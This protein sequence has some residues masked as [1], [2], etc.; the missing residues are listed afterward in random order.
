MVAFAVIGALCGG[1]GIGDG[2]GDDDT[3]KAPS[4]IGSASAGDGRAA[5]E[6]WGGR[7]LMPGKSPDLPAVVT[8]GPLLAKPA[9]SRTVLAADSGA[10]W[11]LDLEA[12]STFLWPLRYTTL[13][14]TTNMDVGPA[15]NQIC[16]WDGKTGVALQSCTT[17]TTCSVAVTRG[18]ADYTSFTAVVTPAPPSTV[19]PTVNCGVGPAVASSFVDVLWHSTGLWLTETAPTVP[20][21][22]TTTLT[23][24]TDYDVGPSPFFVE[25]YDVT[26]AT[27]IRSCGGTPP[28]HQGEPTRC[29]VDVSYAVATTHQYRAC[30]MGASPSFPPPNALEC[31]RDQSVSWANANGT[32]R[33]LLTVTPPPNPGGNYTATAYST[34]NVGPTPY[35]IQIYNLETGSRIAVCGSGTA[36]SAPITLGVNAQNLVGFVGTYSAT[37][38]V[39]LQPGTV[40]SNSLTVPAPPQDGQGTPV[41][42][43]PVIGPNGIPQ[44]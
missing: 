27:M 20:L 3:G 28:P 18:N 7:K 36:C 41:T 29:S 9:A 42:Q 1:C 38:P 5:F 16:I 2:V 4:A 12:S 23:A 19:P 40:E 39:N 33:V 21:G 11:T 44:L 31:T 14:A 37:L 15:H 35:Y 6:P 30:F 25:I 26:T 17:G 32:G 8:D 34:F 22:G 43:G 13:T 10:S 24:I